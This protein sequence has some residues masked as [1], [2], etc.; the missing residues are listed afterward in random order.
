MQFNQHQ[1]AYLKTSTTLADLLN[2]LQ[3]GGLADDD[4]ASISTDQIKSLVDGGK[5]RQLTSILSANEAS[6]LP[7]LQEAVPQMVD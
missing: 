3:S 1:E 4:N 6:V 2:G 5:S 7:A